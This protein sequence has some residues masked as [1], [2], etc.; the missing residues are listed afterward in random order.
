MLTRFRSLQ[1]LFGSL[2]RPGGVV[3]VDD[4]MIEGVSDVD[5]LRKI[6]WDRA[7]GEGL[8][9]ERGVDRVRGKGRKVVEWMEEERRGCDMFYYGWQVA[10]LC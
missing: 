2:K 3:L 7:A 4:N 10:W 6:M 9:Y 5:V 8:E 1:A